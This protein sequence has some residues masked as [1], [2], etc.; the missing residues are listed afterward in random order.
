[1]QVMREL[2]P[3]AVALVDGFGFEDYILNSAL[4]RHDGDVYRALL[5]GAQRSK[6]NNTEEGPG[7]D[8]ILKPLLSGR[9]PRA[10][11]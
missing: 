10:K 6:L 3:D 2:R 8:D 9:K 4:G 11:L 7:W 5:D 1:M